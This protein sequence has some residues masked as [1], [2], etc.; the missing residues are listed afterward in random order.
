MKFDQLCYNLIHENVYFSDI[1]QKIM[2]ACKCRLEDV[3]NGEC[4]YWAMLAVR[5]EPSAKMFHVY[6]RWDEDEEQE[7]GAAGHVFVKVGNKY[8]D[9]MHPAGTTNVNN[10]VSPFYYTADAVLPVTEKELDN[11]YGV[12]YDEIERKLARII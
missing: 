3:N 4:F 12:S 6:S 1:T 9:A 2:R 7:A 10:I 5:K 8:Y 11:L